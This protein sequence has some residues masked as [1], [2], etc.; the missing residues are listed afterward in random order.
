MAVPGTKYITDSEGCMQTVMKYPDRATKA[1]NVLARVHTALVA[2]FDDAADDDV[3]WMPSHN[4]KADVGRKKKS[5]GEVVTETDNKCNDRADRIAKMQAMRHQPPTAEERR[6]VLDDKK[7]GMQWARWIGRA[8]WQASSR[9]GT[10]RRDTQATRRKRKGGKK[11]HGKVVKMRE[12]DPHDNI[13][14]IAKKNGWWC[15]I[16]CRMKSRS[17]RRIMRHRCGGEA[18]DRW[19]ALAREKGIPQEG[20]EHRRVVSGRFIWCHRCGA[21]ADGVARGLAGQC[22]GAASR[23]PGAAKYKQ[24]YYL[25]RGL[26]PNKPHEQLPRPILE[27]PGDSLELGMHA[28]KKRRA[29]DGIGEQTSMRSQKRPRVGFP[30]ATDYPAQGDPQ[31]CGSTKHRSIGDDGNDGRS[32]RGRAGRDDDE[33]R[34]RLKINDEYDELAHPEGGGGGLLPMTDDPASCGTHPNPGDGR[35]DTRSIDTGETDEH[36]GGRCEHPNPRNENGGTRSIGT[37]NIGKN[38]KYKCGRKSNSLV[39][40]LE[41]SIGE[42]PGGD[43]GFPPVTDDPALCGSPPGRSCKDWERIE[44]KWSA[45]S[46]HDIRT[47]DDGRWLNDSIIDRWAEHVQNNTN[48]GACNKIMWCPSAQLSR[49]L[50]QP[51]G[52]QRAEKWRK[53]AGVDLHNL[54]WTILPWHSIGRRHWCI[55]VFDLHEMT[56]TWIDSLGGNIEAE[57][58]MA[59]QRFVEVVLRRTCMTW[60]K[61]HS[62]RQTND[63]DCGVHVCRNISQVANGI[64][65]PGC[66]GSRT[67]QVDV[68]GF[69]R[70]L[71]RRIRDVTGKQDD[72]VRRRI[73]RKSKPSGAWEHLR[74]RNEQVTIS[75]HYNDTYACVARCKRQRTNGCEHHEFFMHDDGLCDT[76]IFNIASDEEDAHVNC[77]PADTDASNNPVN[78]SGRPSLYSYGNR[79]S[80]G[81]DGTAGLNKGCRSGMAGAATDNP[82]QSPPMTEAGCTVVA[83]TAPP[84]GGDLPCTA[85]HTSGRRG[86]LTDVVPFGTASRD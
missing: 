60:V 74:M 83:S 51:D 21:Y 66:N 62:A 57:A 81:A 10:I 58:Q 64:L 29:K 8:T 28:G 32:R 42:R 46:E 36:L 17:R 18:K 7:A 34:K 3:V 54:R 5:N 69:R 63:F 75:D 38:S 80:V 9:P 33:D 84:Y 52:A 13:E 11:L 79:I 43:D 2:A 78:S 70:M 14:M 37:G 45:V 1:K 27:F 39:T 71:Q 31:T 35:G 77:V 49:T 82:A 15:C 72:R 65:R 44:T 59:V 50:M 26:S 25:T 12:E 56:G 73:K 41:R 23:K 68:T 30:P 6:R 20:G 86:V 55:A 85:Q 40:S 48:N 16:R 19:A 22:P 4:T 47:L 76:V 53:R 67:G 24:F 61:T